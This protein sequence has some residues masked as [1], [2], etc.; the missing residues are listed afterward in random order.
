MIFSDPSKVSLTV[1]LLAS[2]RGKVLV[3]LR[4]N[5]HN[6]LIFASCTLKENEPILPNEQK[7]NA[8]L[9]IGLLAFYSIQLK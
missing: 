7:H 1:S 9:L 3:A 2:R 4:I 5:A 6:V 8:L